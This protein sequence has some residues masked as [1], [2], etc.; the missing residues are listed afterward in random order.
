ML[1]RNLY[2]HL[3]NEVNVDKYLTNELK[4]EDCKN[5]LLTINLLD[6]ISH[7]LSTLLAMDSKNKRKLNVY[8]M[9]DFAK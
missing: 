4:E 3:S 9:N 6:Y 1:E 5:N 7:H 8:N 2:V